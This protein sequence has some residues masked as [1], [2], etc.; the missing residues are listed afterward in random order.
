MCN[1][2]CNHAHE[3][4][5]DIQYAAKILC[6]RIENKEGLPLVTGEY[7]SI[8]NIHNPSRCDNAT[9]RWK[10]A[11]AGRELTAGPVSPFSTQTLRPDE[12][13]QIDCREAFRRLGGTLPFLEGW[14]VVESELELDVVSVLTAGA[15]NMVS[16]VTTER[17]PARCLPR[18][19]LDMVF[20]VNTG[21]AAWEVMDGDGTFDLATRIDPNAAWAT[22]PGAEW[23]NNGLAVSGSQVVYQLC[24]ELCSG[25]E[26][27]DL[28]IQFAAD[29][30]GRVDL[31]G[32]P[33]QGG[34]YTT[35]NPW[36][37]GHAQ[38][39]TLTAPAGAFRAGQN[40]I[41]VT[42]QD[43]GNVATGFA[44][45]GTFSA[46]RARCPGSELPLIRCG[47]ICY[48]AHVKGHGWVAWACNGGM[49]GTTGQSRRMEAV[50][51]SL[52]GGAPWMGITYRAHVQNQGW[53]PWVTAGQIA[54]TTG[55]SLRMEAFEARLEDAPPHCRIEYRVHMEKL[56][57]G[58]WTPEGSTAGTTG[59]SRRIEAI[60][61]RFV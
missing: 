50:R 60:E 61:I 10:V 38:A 16:S 42:V 18:C 17:V 28:Q 37:A 36:H 46:S 20:S 2:N 56:G 9:F 25:F 19:D 45:A 48:Q 32:V 49:S 22:I 12:A 8:V 39:Q 44:L 30:Q 51:I 53:L 57:W 1:C 15:D 14:L 43:V 55:Q 52:S 58:P 3:G 27:A 40:C 33:F 13:M 35:A 41:T 11:G 24:F 47:T 7:R 59:Q 5:T 21:T 6:G 4:R 29:D 54:G 23:L 34:N 31:N 26:A